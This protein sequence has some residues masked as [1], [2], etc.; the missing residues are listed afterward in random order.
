M[1]MSIHRE[2]YGETSDGSGT[3]VAICFL[4]L[5]IYVDVLCCGHALT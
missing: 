5:A 2:K 3:F 1:D 4:I